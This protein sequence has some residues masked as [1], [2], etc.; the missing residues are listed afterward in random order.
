M[1]SEVCSISRFLSTRRGERKEKVDGLSVVHGQPAH[2]EPP[3]SHALPTSQLEG[4]G[5][6]HFKTVNIVVY[7]VVLFDVPLRFAFQQFAILVYGMDSLADVAAEHIERIG[8]LLL[9]HPDGSGRHG[10]H[11]V[12]SDCDYS[13]FHCHASYYSLSMFVSFGSS[14]LLYHLP[15]PYIILT[16]IRLSMSFEI[17]LSV[18]SAYRWV[19]FMPECPI[20]LAMLSMGMPSEIKKVPNECL[21]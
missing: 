18:T 16:A 15:V 1:P 3:E 6:H 5:Y 7:P 20:I 8:H 9:R 13:P 10:D 11:P 21:L 2:D 19:V 4:N 12:F 17:F 14:C